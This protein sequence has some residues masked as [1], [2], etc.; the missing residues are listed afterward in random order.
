MLLLAIVPL[1]VIA[2]S[3]ATAGILFVVGLAIVCFGLAGLMR[4]P[5]AWYAGSAAVLLSRQPRVLAYELGHNGVYAHEVYDLI[6]PTPRLETGNSEESLFAYLEAVDCAFDAYQDRKFTGKVSR[7]SPA[8]NT[9]GFL[10]SGA[11]RYTSGCMR[12]ASTTSRIR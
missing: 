1:R 8:V 7:I 9:A 12:I 2:H 5:W 6:R 11:P 4:R 10:T 3:R